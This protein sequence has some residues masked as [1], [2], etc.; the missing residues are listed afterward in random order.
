MPVPCLLAEV[1]AGLKI[2]TDLRAAAV[3]FAPFHGVEKA[4]LFLERKRKKL[5]RPPGGV[6]P[7]WKAQRLRVDPRFPPDVFNCHEDRERPAA[8]TALVA[9][10]ASWAGRG[11]PVNL[12]RH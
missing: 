5:V 9:L 12:V 1:V 11:P 10:E 7:P 2:A 4:A 8:G 6:V 3:D